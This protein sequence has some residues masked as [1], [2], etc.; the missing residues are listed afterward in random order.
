M[1]SSSIPWKAKIMVERWQIHYYTKRPH[2]SLGYRPAAP[3][4]IQLAQVV[5]AYRNR[6]LKFDQTSESGQRNAYELADTVK[7][8]ISLTQLNRD[9]IKNNVEL[10]RNQNLKTR[11]A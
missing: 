9:Q 10:R 3:K 7:P 2:I 11:V 6:T 5:I 4:T 8:P 1:E